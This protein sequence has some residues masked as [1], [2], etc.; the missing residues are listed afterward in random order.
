M[1]EDYLPD[2]GVYLRAHTAPE[3]TFTFVSVPVSAVARVAEDLFSL[4]MNMPHMGRVFML[5][6]DLGRQELIDLLRAMPPALAAQLRDDFGRPFTQPVI[7]NLP[8]VTNVSIATKLGSPNGNHDELYVPLIATSISPA[9]QYPQQERRMPYSAEISRSNPTCLLFL[10]DQSGS[11]SDP[12]G[13][14]DGGKRKA[15]GVA[16]ATNKL[17][18]NL[19]LKCAKEEGIRDYFHVGVIGYSGSGVGPAFGGALAGRE[20]VPISEIG[21]SPARLDE[22]TQERDDGAGGILKVQIKFPIWF[23]PMANGGT[24]MCQALTKARDVLEGWL[25]QHPDAFP[26]I[27]V[28]ITDGEASDGDPSAIA[29]SLKQLRSRTT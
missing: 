16:D 14:A 29:S 21:N 11:M 4:N 5:T 17:L 2:L 3:S 13:G 20:L 28:N 25:R 19:V 24:P 26:P 22:R 15:D 6:V 18:Q 10:V 23:D 12:F 27:V 9:P 8:H 7:A 1:N